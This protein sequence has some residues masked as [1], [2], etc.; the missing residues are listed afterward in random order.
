MYNYYIFDYTSLGLRAAVKLSN[1]ET[2]Y[3]PPRVSST[4]RCDYLLHDRVVVAEER[5]VWDHERRLERREHH[6][7]VK[8]HA[9]R[10]RISL[11]F[12]SRRAN[13]KTLRGCGGPEGL[14]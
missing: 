13:G 6:K 3:H 12:W 2:R 11:I 10:A 9:T 14:A 8:D 7:H 1:N 5:V 4:F